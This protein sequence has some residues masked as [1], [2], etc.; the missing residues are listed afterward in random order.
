MEISTIESWREIFGGTKPVQFRSSTATQNNH[1]VITLCSLHL[2]ANHRELY[3]DQ[4]V[5]LD[6]ISTAQ[7]VICSDFNVSS[8]LM[9]YGST[10][11]ATYIFVFDIT[12][13][14]RV[15]VWGG[16]N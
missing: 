3:S 11:P 5:H 14:N 16:C 1:M 15:E 2:L 4:H 12:M 13:N 10:S 9:I 7:Q 6:P 8:Y